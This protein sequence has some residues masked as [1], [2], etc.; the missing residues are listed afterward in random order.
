VA[1]GKTPFE[2]NFERY[3]WKGNLVVLMEF[4]RLE[5]FLTRLQ[6]SWEKAMKLMEEA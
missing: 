3:T 4:P 1:T 5:E 2:L 6:R